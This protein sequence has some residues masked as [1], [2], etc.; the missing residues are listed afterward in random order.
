MRRCLPLVALALAACSA[1]PVSTDVAALRATADA[2]SK[3]EIENVLSSALGGV[4]ITIAD[5]ALTLEST[6]IMERGM[7]RSVDR[8]PAL[9]RDLGRPNHFQLVLDARQ[10]FLV[11]QETGLRWML[12][13]TECVAE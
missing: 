9:G 11:H 13:Q 12:S 8:A 3:L 7:H 1:N 10:C 2:R 4:D 6:L 5:D